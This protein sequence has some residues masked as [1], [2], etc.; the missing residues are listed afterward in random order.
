[1]LRAIEDPQP[2]ILDADEHRTDQVSD[3]KVISTLF[4]PNPQRCR[5][6][7]HEQESIVKMRMTQRIVAREQDQSQCAGDREEYRSDSAELVKPALVR[8]QLAGVSQPAFRNEGQIQEDNGDDAACDEQ[9]FQPLRSNVRY[10]SIVLDQ[11]QN[12]L[13][14]QART[15]RRHTQ[16]FVRLPCWGR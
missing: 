4:F 13:H 6:Q 10:I 3:T 2:Q 14:A 11:R 7:E 9:R 5:L 12:E 1:M 8:H 15:K 16:W